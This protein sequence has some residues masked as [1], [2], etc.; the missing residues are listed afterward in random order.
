[1]TVTAPQVG[2]TGLKQ[3]K[4]VEFCLPLHY[5]AV[6]P[7]VFLKLC[8][9]FKIFCAIQVTKQTDDCI[10]LPRSNLQ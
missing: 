10:L 9:L 8:M 4:I 3:K 5:S 7:K 6:E 2:V 1:M